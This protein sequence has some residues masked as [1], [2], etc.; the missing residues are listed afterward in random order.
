MPLVF[1]LLIAGLML[2]MTAEPLAFMS[3]VHRAIDVVTTGNAISKVDIIEISEPGVAFNYRIVDR[4]DGHEE[5][6]ILRAYAE[7][8]ASRLAARAI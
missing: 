3:A 2:F 5:Y 1:G 6:A 4:R 8:V 7:Q